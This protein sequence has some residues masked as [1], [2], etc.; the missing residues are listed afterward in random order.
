[1]LRE[2]VSL[3]RFVQRD[4]QPIPLYLGDDTGSGHAETAGISLGKALLGEVQSGQFQMID[5][6]C[7]DLSVQLNH[8]PP[9]RQ[10]GGGH[11]TPDVYLA[12]PPPPDADGHRH[13]ADDR[14]KLLS[15]LRRQHL[16]IAHALEDD[17]QGLAVEGQDN[18][19]GAHRAG[20]GAAACL[21][22]AGNVLVTNG[23]ERVLL[24]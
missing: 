16:G 11:D 1:M 10:T 18:G 23:T 19:R 20:P 7:I 22:Q 2:A 6:E 9:H 17:S 12:S 3:V 14:Q 21:V 24:R 4:H 8:R 15:P 13:L 5:Q